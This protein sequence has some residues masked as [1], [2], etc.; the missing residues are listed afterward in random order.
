[1][2]GAQ[3][4]SFQQSGY[5]VD[6]RQKFIGIDRRRLYRQVLVPQSAQATVTL[7]AIRVDRG[8]LCDVLLDKFLQTL[9]GGIWYPLYSDSAFT[10]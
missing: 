6:A 8:A 1:M 5:D 2:M 4:P 7:P 3:Y 9:S 10:F